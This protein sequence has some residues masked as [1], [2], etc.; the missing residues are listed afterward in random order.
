[1]EQSK[2]RIKRLGQNNDIVYTYILADAG[3]NGM[4]IKNINSKTSLADFI[5]REI[6]NGKI[7]E[8][9]QNIWIFNVIL[10]RI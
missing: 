8:I 3:I 4:I 1:M 10:S 9:I 7:K 5:K 2:Y 6:E